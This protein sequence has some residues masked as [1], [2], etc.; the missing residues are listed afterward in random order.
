MMKYKTSTGMQPLVVLTFCC[1]DEVVSR[2][3]ER[4]QIYQVMLEPIAANGF[5]STVD[6]MKELVT[7][8]FLDRIVA[9]MLM[10]GNRFLQLILESKKRKTETSFVNM[11]T[12]IMSD[13]IIF[14]HF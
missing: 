13:V 3:V 8:L 7:F 2:D 1:S 6:R 4:Q 11:T 14:F 10:N 5:D 9:V 12:P